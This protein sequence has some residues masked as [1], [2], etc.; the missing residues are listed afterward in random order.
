MG[1]LVRWIALS[2]LFFLF[3]QEKEIQAQELYI[4]SGQATEESLVIKPIIRA[5]YKAIGVYP[6]FKYYRGTRSLN[7]VNRGAHDA[8]LARI[9]G[10]NLIYENLVRVDVP[11]FNIKF[12]MIV[13]KGS[14]K[15]PFDRSRVGEVKLAYPRGIEYLKRRLKGKNSWAVIEDQEIMLMLE[16]GRVD[17]GFMPLLTANKLIANYPNLEIRSGPFEPVETYHYI[18]KKHMH[19]KSKLE[20]S[21]RKLLPV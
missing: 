18:H 16:G 2:L 14:P 19:L 17:F 15:V 13:R 4:I 21:L 8:E 12:A 11:V 7:L 6:I 20:L 10:I 5:A 1:K 3:P 9:M